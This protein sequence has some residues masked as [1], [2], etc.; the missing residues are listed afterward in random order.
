[1]S[2]SQ[3]FRLLTEI[4]DDNPQHWDATG[5]TPDSNQAKKYFAKTYKKGGDVNPL[6]HAEFIGRGPV[7]VTHEP[8]YVEAIAL[9]EK[10]AADYEKQPASDKEAAKFAKLARNAAAAIKKD[11]EQ[12][13]NPE[14]TFLFSAAFLKGK[15]GD[16]SSVNKTPDGAKWKGKDA[17]GGGDFAKGSAQDK[18]LVVKGAAYKNIYCVLMREAKNSGVKQAEALHKKNCEGKAAPAAIPAGKSY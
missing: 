4:G 18:A 12:A 3:Q 6:G 9:L 2:R 10:A 8:E 11:P 16:I 17:V 1:M 5:K 15:G 14:Y 13:A 7:Q